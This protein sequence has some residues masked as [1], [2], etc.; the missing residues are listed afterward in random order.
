VVD[1]F[2][3][4]YRMIVVEDGTFDLIEASHWV[5]LFDMDMKYADVM[6]VESVVDHLANLDPGLFDR[7]MPVLAIE[8]AR[9]SS[10]N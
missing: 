9:V 3:H 7:E 4:N 1:G 2:S 5:N 6:T 10:P 8:G